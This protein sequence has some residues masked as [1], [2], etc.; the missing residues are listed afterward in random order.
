MN[1]LDDL[2]HSRL[3]S[4]DISLSANLEISEVK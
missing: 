4:V 1:K 2:H 3:V